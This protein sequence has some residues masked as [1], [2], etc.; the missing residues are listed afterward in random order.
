MSNAPTLFL[1][2]NFDSFSYNLVDEMRKLGFAMQ[3]Y[4]NNVSADKVIEK[5]QQVEGNAM[6]ILS[7]GPGTPAAAGCMPELLKQAQ[8]KYPVLG[9][10]LGHQAI[11]EHYGGEIGLSS[12]VMHGKSSL[13]AHSGDLMFS[14]LQQ[15]LP[16]ARYH[17]L[18]ANHV[19]DCL[20]ILAK[21]NDIPMAVYHPQDKMLGFQFH[22][23]S[24]LTSQ[25]GLLLTQ[26]IE[27]LTQDL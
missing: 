18:M 19:P 27:F 22:P 15:P 11:V 3:V 4:R 23:E 16:V 24:I 25:G 12:E 20:S 7:P 17:S 1:L 13:I 10:C 6:L 26:S 21:F 14:G 8:G 9:I 2:D 5:M